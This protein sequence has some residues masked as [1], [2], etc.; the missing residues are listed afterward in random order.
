MP[1]TTHRWPEPDF[2]TCLNMEIPI[3]KEKLFFLA[4]D[5]GNGL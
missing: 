5:E 2:D 1:T 4:I 3:L